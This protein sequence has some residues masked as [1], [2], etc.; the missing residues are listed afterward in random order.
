MRLTATDEQRAT[1]ADLMGEAYTEVAFDTAGKPR[2]G[3][4]CRTFAAKLEALLPAG[5]A[6][7]DGVI[8]DIF[9]T[10]GC[11]GYYKHWLKRHPEERLDVGGVSRTIPT[12]AGRRVVV[13]GEAVYVQQR[14]FT[15]DADGVQEFHDRH[16]RLGST[17]HGQAALAAA[18]LPVMKEHGCATA[19][20]AIAFLKA[21][22]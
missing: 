13:D 14:F 9:V 6:W 5:H 22:S 4:V 1:I 18:L 17:H 8:H 3:D 15:L 2:T 21:A 7:V 11:A 16:F 19:G 20:D 12:F 10:D